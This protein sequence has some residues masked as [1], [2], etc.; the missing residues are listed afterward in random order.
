MWFIFKTYAPN[1]IIFIR[2][3]NTPSSSVFVVRTKEKKTTMTILRTRCIDTNQWNR[4][5][6][7]IYRLWEHIERYR[8]ISVVVYEIIFNNYNNNVYYISCACT[9]AARGLRIIEIN[10]T[11]TFSWLMATGLWETFVLTHVCHIRVRRH[12]EFNSRSE[13]RSHKHCR[14]KATLPCKTV[15]K[16][17]SRSHIQT[18]IIICA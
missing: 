13:T 15:R 16:Y 14:P 1:R 10:S 18:M 9:C 7:I 12:H 2:F 4:N 11:I 5:L 6:R 17:F 8:I 3:L